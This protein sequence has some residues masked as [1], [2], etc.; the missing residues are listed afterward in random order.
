M[1]ITFGETIRQGGGN[2]HYAITISG[3]PYICCS[4]SALATAL[5]AEDSTADDIRDVILGDETLETVTLSHNSSV[6]P[7]FDNLEKLGNQSWTSEESKGMLEG[8]D[9]DIE[10]ADS[11]SGY[12]WQRFYNPSMWGLPGIHSIAQPFVQADFPYGLL[13]ENFLRTDSDLT[14][15]DENGTT[16][17]TIVDD[18]VTASEVVFVWVGSECV[19]VDDS[20]S[21]ANGTITLD[22][23]AHG[24]FRREH[25]TTI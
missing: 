2:I 22:V 23:A 7:A 15:T 21:N 17:Y 25:R 12:D 5:N 4:S 8:G 10:I 16:L 18:A 9:F 14:C 19:A 6:C 20:T 13:T 11:V 24:L 1:A 3:Y